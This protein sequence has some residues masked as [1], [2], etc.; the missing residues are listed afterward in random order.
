MERVFLFEG[1]VE[2]QNKSPLEGLN[3]SYPLGIAYLD[4]VLSEKGMKVITKDYANWQKGSF[5]YDV[6]EIC[7]MFKPEVVG[8]SVMSMTRVSTY[9]AIK[10]IKSLDKGIKIVLGGMHSSM[11][12]KQLLENFEIDAICIGESEETILELVDALDKGTSLSKVKG[13]VYKEKNK[14]KVTPKRE[15]IKNLDDI[16]FPNHKAFMNKKR[17]RAFILSSRGCPNQCS[18]CCLHII[19]HRR[20]RIRSYKSV[21]DEI[22]F[23]SKKFPQIKEIE[24][25]DDTL[26]LDNKRVIDICKEIIKRKIKK[27]FYCSGR[28]KPVSKEMFYW[29][30]KAGFVEIRFGIESASKK[31]MASIN[32]GISQED[33]MNAYNTIKPFKKIRVVKY[34][35]VGFPGETDETI[36][37]TIEFTKKLQKIIP[38]D[39]FTATPLW[40]YPGT[41]IYDIMKSKG[42][43]NDDY[44]L[45]NK[46]CPLY[47]VEHSEEK[48]K[49]MAN[50]IAI[51]TAA[52]QGKIF[53]IRLG[54]KKIITHP[55]YY[56]SR[57]KYLV[58]RK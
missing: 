17:I 58:R 49:E 4:S 14:I 10:L 12:Y 18:F 57:V 44:W 8:I 28:V 6:K 34:L 1:C 51:E 50:R 22:E 32:K 47:T 54:L 35:M 40:V 24:F 56:F 5:L 16:P 36:N 53:F 11:M 2:D 33:I 13:I 39:F 25:V 23:L 30:E 52:A 19:S 41:E 7:K 29:M 43:I 3:G 42:K 21:V 26:I 48:L 20:Y 15:L 37:E 31:I 45:T 9:K 27:R 38:M 55:K 46:P